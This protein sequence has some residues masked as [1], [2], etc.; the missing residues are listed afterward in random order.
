MTRIVIDALVHVYPSGGVRALDGV[1]LA[2]APGERVAL[3]GQ[4]G[5]GKSTLV[6][7][8]NGLLR[9]TSGQVLLDVREQRLGRL[10]DRAA[11]DDQLGIEQDAERRHHPRGPS[12]HVLK[13]A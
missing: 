4:N 3:V 10:G 2:I 5:S 12:G 11:E 8:L 13:D 7:H 1:D 6:Q 9:P